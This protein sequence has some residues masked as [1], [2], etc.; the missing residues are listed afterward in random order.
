M[1]R[2]YTELNGEDLK[3]MHSKTSLLDR[4]R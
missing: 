4:L 3:M 1:T 2:R